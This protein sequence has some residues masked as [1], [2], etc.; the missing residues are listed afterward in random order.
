VENLTS[1]RMI[2]VDMDGTLLGSDGRVSARNLAAMVAAEAAGLQV[3]VAT[4]R[5]HCYAMRQLRGLGLADANALVSSNGTVT[6]MLGAGACLIN[7]NFLSTETALLLCEHLREFRNA[8]VLTFD[9]VGVDGEDARGAL[10]VEHMEELHGSIDRWMI[11]N[12]PYIEQVSPIERAL[13]DQDGQ[14]LDP[15]IQMMVCGTIDRMQRAEARLLELPGVSVAGLTSSLSDHAGS[16]HAESDA[17]ATVALSR[18]EYPDRDLSIVD[19]LPAGCSKGAALLRL[20]ADWGIRPDEMMAIGDNWNDV[21]MLKIAGQAVLMENA[22]DDLKALATEKGWT[23]GSHHD[24]NGVA[25]AIERV[26]A[27]CEQV[28]E[29]SNALNQQISNQQVSSEQMMST[30]A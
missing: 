12:A 22:P 16:G 21:S 10:V 26:L 13:V 29:P 6:R 14:A 24:A 9:R 3:V 11:A 30:L 17:A 2:A 1:I 20:A 15:P 23:I 25:E 4:G 18:T 19:I 27:T 8:L 5:R 7:R 28:L